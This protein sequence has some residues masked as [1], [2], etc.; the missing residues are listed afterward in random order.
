MWFYDNQIP[1][2]PPFWFPGHRDAHRK[3]VGLNTPE[4]LQNINQ[5]KAKQHK[6]KKNSKKIKT[7]RSAEITAAAKIL[8]QKQ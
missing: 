3:E 4:Q 6:V 8:Q 7:K 2:Q 1:N 5:S